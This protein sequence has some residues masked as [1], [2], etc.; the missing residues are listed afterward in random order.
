MGAGSDLIIRIATQGA[1]LAKAQLNSLGK[2]STL[3]GGKFGKLAKVGVAGLAV[4]M[5][6]VAKAV[7]TSVKA[8]TEFDDKMTQ[9][10]AIMNTTVEQQD[11]M[12]Q[13]ARD[14]ALQTTI[15]ADQSAEAYFFLAS[16]GLDAEQ[17]I[18][19]LP[20]V[21]AFAQAGMFDMATAT[22]LATDAQS[23]LGLSVDDAQKNLTNLT[24]VT[25]V[26]VKA[27]T[28][29][30]ATVQQFSEAL[31]TKAGAALKVVNKDVE[32]GVAVLA[33]FADRGVKGAEA[34]DK[35]NQILRDI[36]R[37]TSKNKKEFEALGLEM[38]DAQGN[39]RN[40]ADVIEELDR[41]L[42]PM[43][44]EM[45]AA[46]LDQ[47]GLN[48]GVADGIKILSGST[49]QI[50][51]YE[52]ELRAAS[53]TTQEIAEKQ[54]ESFKA[55]T[56]ILQN[57][58]QNLAIIIGEDI[59]PALEKAVQFFQT[60]TERVVAF[61]QGQ[62]DAEDSAKKF[63]LAVIGVVAV[64]GPLAPVATAVGIAIAGIVKIIGKG[65]EEFRKQEE[66]GKRVNN[67]YERMRNQYNDTSDE[68]DTFIDTTKS[69]D[70]IL[71][72]TNFTVAELTHLLDKNGIALNDNAKEALQTAQAYE[73]GL[74]GG[75]QSVMQAFDQLQ[76]IQDRID[77]AETKRN[78]E[79]AKKLKA[80]EAVKDATT[81]LEKA[82]QKLNDVKGLGAI[83][84]AE[85]E[86][87]ILRQEQ[88]I[89][90][91]KEAE[92]LSAIQ[93]LELQI[94]EEGLI[95]LREDS[96]ALSQE[97]E[98]ALQDVKRAEETLTRAKDLQTEAIDRVAEAQ[99]Q[100]N[101]LSEK[102]AR[103]LLE[104][105]IAQENLTKALAGFGV[106]TKGFE[107]AL[108]KLAKI[109]GE[110]IGEI[111]GLFGNLFNNASNLSK[112]GIDL[113]PAT[114]TGGSSGGGGGGSPQKF[115]ATTTTTSDARSRL[116]AEVLGETNINIFNQGTNVGTSD[117][118]IE[119][120]STAFQEAKKRGVDFL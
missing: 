107:D 23:A 60:A 8:F 17:S 1:N 89:N 67:V 10:L 116:T 101:K 83:V 99:K 92:E 91:L 117:E 26:L 2:S 108:N 106:G 115:P 13:V 7:S 38:F 109:T 118:F 11:K 28:L 59:V 12:A 86:L 36:P 96:V 27:N 3:L 94:L 34:G 76:A 40:V 21:A 33:A 103:N 29:A 97:E 57:T 15:S 56:Q 62:K 69:L 39:F 102:S 44:D 95:K 43:S 49:D 48:R 70:D 93:K 74:F 54:L 119:S 78:K 105:A 32:E 55:Q 90:E 73:D 110:K 87:A 80:D 82:Q 53:G 64:L 81:E 114:S 22:D 51:E 77:S 50:R 113:G 66:L 100:L 104:Q 6:G 41:V 85:E 5:I 88:A 45:K 19:A 72:G 16:A 47:L 20:Q 120:V 65:N 42:G 35:L 31:T 61:K 71:D 14:V 30:N 98:K 75:L 63:K 79:V 18:A 25:D 84:T 52:K 58:L 37:A 112:V 4:A 46:T 111:N 68:A 9:S 24:R